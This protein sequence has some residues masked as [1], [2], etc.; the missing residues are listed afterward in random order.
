[1]SWGR[2][3]DATFFSNLRLLPRDILRMLTVSHQAV[4]QM[5]GRFALGARGDECV[6]ELTCIH[7]YTQTS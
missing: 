6:F 4:V 3:C 7:D 2:R 5:A 1:M